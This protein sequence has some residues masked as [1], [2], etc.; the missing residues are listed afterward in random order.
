MWL[1]RRF[2]NM[3]ANRTSD[4]IFQKVII[5]HYVRKEMEFKKKTKNKN[6]DIFTLHQLKR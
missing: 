6:V 5:D 4:L 3:F 1:N 2:R